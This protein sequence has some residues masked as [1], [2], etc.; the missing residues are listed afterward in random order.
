MSEPIFVIITEIHDG[1]STSGTQYKYFIDQNKKTWYVS[2]PILM[3]LLIK[4]KA[5]NITETKEPQDGKGTIIT[6]LE[7][8]I[9]RLQQPPQRQTQP[10]RLIQK[11]LMGREDA[12]RLCMM[13]IAYAKDLCI[14]SIIPH[15]EM[16]TEAD[17][18]IKWALEQTDKLTSKK[19]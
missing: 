12:N 1:Q 14:N 8:A 9:N 18:I 11:P 19:Q 17:K 7:P 15:N 16:F 6:K 3:A 10:Q 2:D 4:N 13:S 5:F